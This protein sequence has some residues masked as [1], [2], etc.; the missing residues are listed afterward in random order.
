MADEVVPTTNDKTNEVQKSTKDVPEKFVPYINKLRGSRYFIGD[1]KLYMEAGDSP[2]EVCNF[3]PV[4]EEQI[5][6][7]NGKDVTVE[8]VVSGLLLQTLE[9]L[10]Q[11]VLTKQQLESFN[12]VLNSSWKIKA[13][14]SAGG[15]KDRVREVSQI[16]SKD[17]IKYTTVYSYSGFVT[18]NDKLVYLYHNGVIGDCPDVKVDLSG[19][20]LQQYCMTDKTF[21][22]KEC[23]KTSYSILDIADRSITLPLLATTYLAPLTTLLR[24]HNI[25][26]DYV[27]WIEGKSGTRKSTLAALALSH[28]GDFQRNTFPCSFRDTTNSLE[29]KA[30]IMKDSLYCVDDYCP[31]TVG[32]RKKGVAEKLLA[33]FGDRTGRDR[34]N[35]DGKTLRSPYVARGQCIVTG[36]SFPEI[37]QSRLARSFVV[38][39]HKDS[40][41]LKKLSVIQTNRE[42]LA[43]AMMCYIKWI[44]ENS[45][46]VMEKA[47]DINNTLYKQKDDS[48]HGRLNETVTALYIGF[49]TFVD[50]LIA[51]GVMTSKEGT[52]LLENALAVFNEN[53]KV[54]MLDVEDTNPVSMFQNALE[55]LYITDKVF[56]KNFHKPDNNIYAGSHIG[57]IDDIKNEY[58]FFPDVLYGEIVRFYNAQGIRFPI[59]KA[60]LWK[61]LDDAGILLRSSKNDRRT[62]RRKSPD[63]G[64]NN[65][66]FIIIPMEKL[67]DNVVIDVP[68]NKRG[69]Y[70]PR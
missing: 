29:K 20:K 1:G 11:V 12:F 47:T 70:I 15:N 2:V 30:F 50:F 6:Y 55:Q 53:A 46:S 35:Q 56:V 28:Y 18:K 19:D 21:N 23:L 48:V 34:M 9:E 31:E 62:T 52:A 68:T 8:Y 10:P 41:D 67:Q 51:N 44:I 37:S 4:I 16:V 59:S 33:M 42:H 57:Y 22:L 40:I 27:L 32:S 63:K 17:S 49:S 5:D 26:A 38:E 69:F 45:K 60:S 54:Q 24:E 43:Y 7:D 25:L 61:Y 66:A 14:I 58:L 3:L 64:G 65:I 36:E 13:I 39:V